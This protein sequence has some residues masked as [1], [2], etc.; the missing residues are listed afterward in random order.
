[1][2]KIKQNEKLI[3]FELPTEVGNMDA[4]VRGHSKVFTQVVYYYRMAELTPN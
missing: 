3:V 1:M 2:Q 4:V